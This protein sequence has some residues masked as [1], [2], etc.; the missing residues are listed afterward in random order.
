MQIGISTGFYYGQN[1]LEAINSFKDAG[2]KTLEVFAAPRSE[3]EYIHFNWHERKVVDALK[4]RLLELGM[5]VNSV[6]APFSNSIDISS[7]DDSMRARSVMEIAECLDVA[8]ELGAGFLVLH[9]ASAG[10]SISELERR[11][12]QSRKSLEELY[13]KALNSGIKLAVENQLPHILGGNPE[14]L[15]ALIEGFSEDT[16]CF[17]FD[18]S[19]ANLYP[20]KNVAAT[21][22]AMASRIGTLHISDNR[23]TADDHIT[24]GR[25]CINWKEFIKTLKSK[26]YEGVFMLEVIEKIEGVSPLEILKAARKQAEDFLNN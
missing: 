23:G 3:F 18:S 9:P 16:A 21:F 15:H 20:P 5:S 19:H 13:R 24:P 26:N 10:G 11:F 25:G 17:C 8:R 6:H 4:G 12:A 22:A 7:P 2:F 14:T 1:I